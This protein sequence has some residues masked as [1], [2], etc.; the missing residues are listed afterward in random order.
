MIWDPER[1]PLP[2]DCFPKEVQA[3][4]AA[5]AP[6]V[7]V[8]PAYIAAATLPALASAIGGLTS[9][10]L[11]SNWHIPPSLYLGLVGPPS[12]AK[13]PAL[14]I[15][16]APVRA[17][18][19]SE[20]ETVSE[21]DAPDNRYLVD[22]VTA[23]KLAELL[24]ENERGL[25]MAVDELKGFFGGMGQYK[26]GNGRDRQFYLSAWSGQP[27]TVD[28]IKR[29]SLHVSKPTLAIV[30]GIQPAVFDQLTDGEP[31]GMM[32]RFLLVNGIAVPSEWTEDDIPAAV[33]GAY[34]DLWNGVR[35]ANTQVRS[36]NLTPAARATWKQ[37]YDTFH[38][39]Q[40][41]DRLAGM[42]GKVRTH[43]ARIA[44]VLA[45]ADDTDVRPEHVERAVAITDWFL[46]ETLH[47][48][49]TAESSRPDERRHIKVRERVAAF[50]IAFEAEHGRR[51]TKSEAMR[52]GPYGARRARDLDPIL[53]ELGVA[54]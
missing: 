10:A 25:L 43:V 37:W 47:V 51:P 28:R 5:G 49:R 12:A 17:A 23:E 45:C 33:M 3:L 32:E 41:V 13:T 35:D 19:D 20:W 48:L 7:S 42:M 21:G 14:G 44:L 24:N 6:I 11:R 27:I 40:P 54:L 38:A 39:Q 9:L 26:D 22:D 34:A 30:G 36:I 46:G 2:L 18:E 1:Q 8:D 15:A 29:G 16:L 31:D 52:L 4:T 53:D 50:L